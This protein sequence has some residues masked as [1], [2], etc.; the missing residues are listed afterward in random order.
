MQQEIIHLTVED[1]KQNV[2][3][4][5][6]EQAEV[7]LSDADL[8]EIRGAMGVPYNQLFERYHA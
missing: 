6:N 5:L 8:A 3:E 2:Q 7:E 4:L 1:E